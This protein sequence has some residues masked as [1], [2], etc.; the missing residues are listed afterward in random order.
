MKKDSQL[1]FERK[2]FQRIRDELRVGTNEADNQILQQ[3]FKTLIA[4]KKI[5]E[6]VNKIKS[7]YDF[8]VNS[9]SIAKMKME[10]W[11]EY[12]K[13]NMQKTANDKIVIFDF[14]KKKIEFDSFEH[15][16]Q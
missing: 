16:Y 7:L 2:H 13:E 10:W 12:L 11:E 3:I 5:E 1:E 6:I 9:T 14:E 8:A 15:V 4:E